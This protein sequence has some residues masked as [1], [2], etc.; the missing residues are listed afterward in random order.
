MIFTTRIHMQ[1]EKEKKREREENMAFSLLKLK[2][3]KPTKKYT[4][5]LPCTQPPGSDFRNTFPSLGPHTRPSQCPL[6][7]GA[8][9][10][11]IR[12]V[13]VCPGCNCP[14]CS[15]L[16]HVLGRHHDIE[17]ACRESRG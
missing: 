6:L 10:L 3:Q 15:C 14:L 4:N 7:L 9:L 16:K 1:R 13:G 12:G 11:H 2:K 8:G 5:C 17:L